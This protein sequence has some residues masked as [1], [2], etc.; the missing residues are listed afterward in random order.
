V[1]K[2]SNFRIVKT[3]EWIPT[4]FCSPVTTTKYASSVVQK[5]GKQIQDGGRPPSWIWQNQ[6][7][8]LLDRFWW[9]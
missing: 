4:K 5:R 8:Q 6:V 2:H 1:Q 3:T 7:K 9:N